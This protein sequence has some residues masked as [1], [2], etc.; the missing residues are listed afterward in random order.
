[1]RYYVRNWQ[2]HQHYKN[3]NPPWIKLHYALLS[4][5]D[6][7]VLDDASRVLAVAILLIASRNNGYIDG[8]RKGLRYIQRVAYLNSE[9]DLN[10]LIETGFLIADSTMLA[11]ASE[12][13]RSVRPET[14]TET[15][16]ET[17]KKGRGERKNDKRFAPP[18]VEEVRQYITERGSSIDPE[19]FVDF[20]ESKGWM[21]GRNKM[22]SWKACV[23]TWERKSEQENPKP[24]ARKRL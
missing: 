2:E 10:P 23:R 18:T 15:E 19:R 13:H 11:D 17:E 20:Y 24:K 14:E 7:V 9:P 22:K 21:V 12:L 8:S 6:W 5:E 1:M 4:S 16:T 3:R